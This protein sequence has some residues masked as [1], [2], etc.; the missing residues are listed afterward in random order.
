MNLTNYSKLF[1]ILIIGLLLNLN[2]FTQ[3]KKADCRVLLSSISGTY[4]GGC[5]DGFAQGKGISQGTDKYE[6][7]F[8]KGLPNGNGKYTWANGNV[9]NGKWK[10]GRRHGV[11][12]LYT[13]S[14][15]ESI[16][17]LW[18]SDAFIK[19][20]VEPG[21]NVINKYNIQSIS[22]VKTGD[23]ENM[24]VLK[25]MRDGMV[26]PEIDDLNIFINNGH[27]TKT[28]CYTYRSVLVPWTC[29]I[30]FTSY[31]RLSRQAL[32]CQVNFNIKEE[33]TWEVI[34]KY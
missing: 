11:G 17:G 15:G 8:K 27:L 34:I 4:E 29:K 12:V 22:I 10:M 18:K 14:N 7:K 3:D 33:G 23:A 13:A 2:S 25:F 9:Y 20:I 32:R 6:G 31:T 28:N 19:E 16:K 26:T 1:F 30:T 24:V 21:F 5:K